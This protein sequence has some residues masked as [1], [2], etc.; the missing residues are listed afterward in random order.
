MNEPLRP[1]HDVF[2]AVADGTRRQIMRMLADEDLPIKTIASHFPITRTA[3]NKHLH[4]LSE[5]GLV[6]SRRVG[7]ETRYKLQAQPLVEIRQWMSFY[8]RYWDENLEA[9]RNY[10]E[11]DEEKELN[12]DKK[13]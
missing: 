1:R 12:R 8:E 2:Q 4:V 13:R 9:L 6:S 5:A 11:K 3:V 10:V 7:R